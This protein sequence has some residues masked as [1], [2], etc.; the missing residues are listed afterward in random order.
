MDLKF[1]FLFE[2]QTAQEIA[3][4]IVKNDACS[5]S[6]S[7]KFQ[8]YYRFFRP[9]MPIAVRQLLQRGRKIEVDPRWYEPTAFM[10]AIRD[11]DDGDQKFTTIHPWP[12]GFEFSLVL[13]HDVET[14]EGLRHVGR[15]A[16]LEEGLGLRSS[17][18]LIPYKYR[19]DMGLVKDLQSRGFEIGIHG[20]N[21]D[22]QLFSSRRVFDRR[23]IKINDALHRFGARP[24]FGLR[25]CTAI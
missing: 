24:A 22:G 4:Q 8:I 21:H 11:C 20:Y 2:N 12:N 19:I 5:F 10:Q 16:D 3:S 13:T 17:W 1:N 25:W 14:A 23:A 18:N 9:I 6:L 7:R 15:I